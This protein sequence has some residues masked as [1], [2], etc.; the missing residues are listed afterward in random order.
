[1]PGQQKIPGPDHP[2][3]VEKN[4]SRVT[5]RVGDR[6]IADTTA[7]MELRESTYP[8]AQYIPLADVDQ[9]VLRATETTTYCPYKGDASY[10]SLNLPEGELT[11]VIWTY[12]TPYE[13]VA[14]I[15]DHVAF[16]PNKVEIT[17]S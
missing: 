14:P 5:V 10:Y 6:V 7:A 3:T 9:S 13:P 17:V 8:P 16:Y 12:R 1:M 11:D 2:I 4:P 15:A